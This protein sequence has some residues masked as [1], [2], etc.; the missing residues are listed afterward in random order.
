MLAKNKEYCSIGGSV[1]FPYL[2]KSEISFPSSYALR[3]VFLLG[4]LALGQWFLSD[5]AELPGGGLGL[6][7]V[8]AGIW[9]FAQPL[10]SKFDA[11]KSVNGWKKRCKKVL[12]QFELLDEE[13]SASNNFKLR[14]NSLDEIIN[15]QGPQ[16]IAFINSA[17]VELPNKKL[18]ES[19]IACSYPVNLSW[20]TSLPNKDNSWQLPTS[21][22]EK[23]VIVYTLPL[24][25][26]AVDLLWLDK[27]PNDQPAWLIV[28]SDD[29]NASWTDQLRALKAQLPD[30]W[31]NNILKWNKSEQDLTKLLKPVRRFLDNPK[32]N[33]DVTKRR[34]LCKLHSS[35]QADLE[36]LRRNK[37][38]VIQKKTQWVVAGAVFASPVPSTDLLAISV[39]NGLMIKE[40]AEIWSCSWSPESLKIVA[41]QLAGAAVAQGIVEWSGQTLLSVAKLHGTSWLAAGTMQA[42]SAAYLTRVV[43]RS[44]SDWMALNNGVKEPDLE[45]LKNEAPKLIAKAAKEERVDW[46]SFIK[47]A[48][49]WINNK[50]HSPKLET[51]SLEAN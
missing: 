24:P 36:Y 10:K 49:T 32:M 26:R 5:V 44:M 1:K 43:G 31:L 18:V 13:S 9:W 34:L 45:A 8:G 19:A 28:S 38:R 16:N 46:S 50:T 4:S 37:F 51:I 7:L 2:Q 3:V 39:A 29:L 35:W 47:Q 14:S 27:V 48:N 15:R 6:F 42:L 22:F 12:Q 21:L 33:I 30:R 23:D 11:P 25:L 17:G 40:M 41:K 20:S